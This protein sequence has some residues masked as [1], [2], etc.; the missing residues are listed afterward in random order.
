MVGCE[1]PPLYL[2]GTSRGLLYY[3]KLFYGC[4]AWCTSGT[5][6]GGR[7]LFIFCLLLGL[8][9]FYLGS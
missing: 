4:V 6:N 1:H 9:S 3:T 7:C 2:S 8:F 5:P